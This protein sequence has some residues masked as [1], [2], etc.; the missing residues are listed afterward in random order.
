MNCCKKGQ[1][2]S[3]LDPNMLDEYDQVY[4]S[5]NPANVVKAN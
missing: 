5:I 2:Y 3:N 1:I 4:L